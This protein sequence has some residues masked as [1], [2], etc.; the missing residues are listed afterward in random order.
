[1]PRMMLFF[2]GHSHK[3]RRLRLR[4]IVA[5]SC[6][7]RLNNLVLRRW[8]RLRLGPWLEPSIPPL[9]LQVVAERILPWPA[10]G[11][12]RHRLVRAEDAVPDIERDA[13][14]VPPHVLVVVEI[15]HRTPEP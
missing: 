15:V 13:E 5:L 8:L 4:A 2:M 11:L 12:P 14:I 10:L 7:S 1:M 9:D 6:A 3:N